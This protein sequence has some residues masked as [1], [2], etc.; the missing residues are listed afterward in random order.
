MSVPCVVPS[1]GILCCSISE[2]GPL[3]VPADLPWA[4]GPQNPPTLKAVG[5]S[6]RLKAL[7]IDFAQSESE[8]RRYVMEAGLGSQ[9]LIVILNALVHGR[10]RK[11]VEGCGRLRKLFSVL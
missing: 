4:I 11:V 7:G 1:V 9:I 8:L 5:S 3:L 10:L 6:P 2:V